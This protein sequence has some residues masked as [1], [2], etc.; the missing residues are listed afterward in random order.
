MRLNDGREIFLVQKNYLVMWSVGGLPLH[1][2]T[3][4]SIW[5]SV[6]QTRYKGRVS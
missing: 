6:C 4:L 3:I 2:K 1:A 5:R